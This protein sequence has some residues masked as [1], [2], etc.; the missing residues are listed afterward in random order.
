VVQY[1]GAPN[2]YRSLRDER[3]V[4]R[5]IALLQEDRARAPVPRP[6]D[7]AVICYRQNV[8]DF[9]GAG[10]LPERVLPFGALRGT[11]ALDDVLQLYVVGRPFPPSYDHIYLAQVIHHDAS[12]ICGQLCLRQRAY[13]GQK[14]AIEVVDYED[15]R[16]AEL[17]RA[18]REDELVQ[19]IHRARLLTLLP[20]AALESTDRRARVRLVL[21]ASHPVPGLRVDELILPDDDSTDLNAKRRND[22]EERVLR[23]VAELQREGRPLTMRAISELAHADRR[24]VRKALDGGLGKVVVDTPIGGDPTTEATCGASSG[25]GVRPLGKVVDTPIEDGEEAVATESPAAKRFRL[26]TVVDTPTRDLSM[27]IHQIPQTGSLESS[28]SPAREGASPSSVT[29]GKPPAVRAHWKPCRGGCGAYMPPGQACFDCAC[30][31]VMNWNEAERAQ[32]K[33]KVQG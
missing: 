27:G 33:R 6:E 7:E 28:S 26:G 24:T 2:G 22:A 29:T 18:R 8:D 9:L 10:F 15:E 5:A 21:M 19:V 13:G 12:P 32:R 20:Q 31:L 14:L 30:R 3:G 16:V 11:N 4:E 25:S 17:L 1:A 23:A